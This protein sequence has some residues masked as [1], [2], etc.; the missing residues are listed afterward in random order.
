MQ[1][2]LERASIETS[3]LL[4]QVGAD[5]EHAD[6]QAAIVEQDVH[7]ANKVAASVMT[8]KTDC[9]ADLAEAMPAYEAA[10]EALR[11]L[12]KK[13]LQELKGFANPPE[14]VKFTVIFL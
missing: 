14:M 6:V 7:E 9:E 1:P 8:I 13:S 4:V 10:V 11:T 2:V 3:E 5:Q 12:D